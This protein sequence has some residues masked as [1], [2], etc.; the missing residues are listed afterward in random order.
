M[1]NYLFRNS[2]KRFTL[3]VVLLCAVKQGAVGQINSDMPIYIGTSAEW[4]ALA[5]SVSAGNNYKGKELVLTD[6]ITVTTMIGDASH[7]FSGTF[8][9]GDYTLTVDYNTSSDYTAPF[10]YVNNAEIRNLH[11]K[12]SITTSG[13]YAAG[14]IANATGEGTATVTNCCVSVEMKSTT[15][16]D[17]THGGLVALNCQA[18]LQIIG[19]LFDGKLLGASTTNCGGFVGWNET[20]NNNAHVDI[21][22][23][24][25]A[26]AELTMQG[27]GTFYR[28]RTEWQAGVANSYYLTLFGAAQG[29]A[30]HTVTADAGVTID[31]AGK[32]TATYSVGGIALYGDNGGMIYNSS[33][34]G[35]AGD[36]VTLNLSG[37]AKYGYA[38]SSGT[39]SGTENPY[40]LTMEDADAVISI[41]PP[42]PAT[43]VRTEDELRDAAAN[44]NASIRF[45]NDIK[46]GS[47][48]VIEGNNTVTIDLN[49]FVLDRG[50]MAR[51]DYGQVITVTEGSMINLS[52]G[53][54]TG[55]W[56]GDGGAIRN[57]GIASLTNV[58]ITGN[59][60]N[61]RGG[62]ISNSGTLVM[63]DCTISGN[64]SIDNT[65]P[66]GG[67]AIYNYEGCTA[68]LTNVTITGNTASQYGGG[69]INNYGTLT[70]DGVT[71]SGNTSH[72]NGSGIWNSESATLNMQGK[73]T[74][75]DNMKANGLGNNVYLSEGVLITVTDRLVG[76][77]VGITLETSGTFTSGYSIHNSGTNPGSIFKADLCDVMTVSLA[78]NEAQIVNSLPEGAVYYIE[79]SWDDDNKCIKAEIKILDSDSYIELTGGGKGQLDI[80]N[81][82]VVKGNVTYDYFH[83][84]YG[85][86]AHL[87]LCDGAKLSAKHITVR[88]TLCI[89]GQ[90]DDSGQLVL[91]GAPEAQ[92]AIGGDYGDYDGTGDFKDINIHGGDIRVTG[93]ENAAGIGG[94]T[95]TKYKALNIYGGIINATGGDSGPGIG[96]GIGALWIVQ[97]GFINIYGGE[98]SAYGGVDAAGIG[99]GE[100]GN[101][102]DVTIWGGNVYALG[103]DG[104]G[105]G[106]GDSG[107]GGRVTING[108]RVYASG[109]KEGTSNGAGI[110]G[111]V[112][113]N[114]YEVT[115]NGG[116]VVAQG[117]NKGAGIGGGE[118]GTGGKVTINGGI[119]IAEAGKNETGNRAIGPGEDNDDY[120]ELTI[121]DGMMVSSERMARA[122]ERKNMCWYRTQVRVEP[123]THQNVTYTV[124]GATVN[125]THTE[126]CQYCTTAFASEKH[127]FK[128][129]T[130]TVCG[131]TESTSIY[132]VSVY[133]PGEGTRYADA[134]EYKMIDGTIFNLPAAPNKNIP[135][136]LE[137]AGWLKAT[138]PDEEPSDNIE[139]SGSETLLPAGTQYDVKGDVK[140]FARYKK[141]DITLADEASNGETL[142]LY[143]GK[144]VNSV[145]LSGRTLYRDG[146]WNTLCLPFDVNDFSG[147]A[148]ADATVK[149][150]QASSFDSTDGTLT[151]TFNS[152]SVDKIM[153]GMPYIVKW[154]GGADLTDPVFTGVTISNSLQSVTTTTQG[155]PEGTKV[156]FTGSFSPLNIDE[157]N[158]V[159]LY[160]GADN[161]LYYP[162]QA[163]VINACRAYFKLKGISAGDLPAGAIYL[164]FGEDATG[165]ETMSDVSTGRRT[166]FGNG[167][168]SDAWYTLDGR[169]LQGKPTT[170]GVYI[171]NGKKSVE[172]GY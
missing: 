44:D 146:R 29:K 81:Y 68:T 85:G 93:G 121:G 30:A 126:H 103:D 24:V 108:G 147:T 133:L 107:M 113:G 8:D 112:D 6:N 32:S 140:F 66:A 155:A 135:I 157:E 15:D 84:G 97:Y 154:N 40:T 153:A 64:T 124:S 168:M 56:G 101:G 41:V 116:Y 160:L 71:I 158:R 138:S 33:I 139:T 141:I 136:N 12:G 134:V 59:H 171:Y 151:I 4:D 61:D 10:R 92:A 129:G 163:M 77:T 149:T 39:I 52:N 35:A 38:T 122:E 27:S 73:V 69:G 162:D 11:V 165:I 74:V 98:I 65:L 123:C 2:C 19:C 87:I 57:S 118:D 109:Y 88:E 161:K 99:T 75:T 51:A 104:A 117:G 9:G 23:C 1:K 105:I 167:K 45:A 110:G 128:N 150:L 106:G 22:D 91:Q 17:G 42:P 3:L 55:G 76:S 82:Y 127:T 49:G 172:S 119:V 89:Y 131:I 100:D 43:I 16:G 137:F 62:G 14:L 70:L 28:T 86:D 111:G 72:A 80:D 143:D 83:T 142:S 13:K 125:D 26:P 60:A 79:R 132:T 48:L 63:T 31:K 94:G 114:G 67:G 166:E 46:I 152:G 50:L 145:T 159:L 102:P 120:G 164:N 37:S 58:N 95:F 34:Y 130:C 20:N 156:T 144:Q 53:T 21:T 7:S 5:E 148:L 115:I 96:L 36:A 169:K 25:F 18:N 47:S 170:K 54:L 90:R 78:D